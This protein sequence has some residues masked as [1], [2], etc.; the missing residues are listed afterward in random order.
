MGFRKTVVRVMN[1][2]YL[3]GSAVAIYG[4]CTKPI[5]SVDLGVELSSKQVGKVVAKAF[6]VEDKSESRAYTVRLIS[7]AEESET[8]KDWLTEAKIAKA[9]PN[10]LSIHKP[11]EIP[12]AKA[13]EFKNNKIVEE[14]VAN[15]LDAFINEAV[16][17]ITPGVL[18]LFKEA[19]EDK[20]KDVLHEQ[21]DQTIADFFGDDNVGKVSDDEVQEIFDNIYALVENNSAS[22]DQIT[23]AIL[24]DD[25]TQAGL[26]K[27]LADR[28]A[29]NGGMQVAANVT[30]EEYDAEAAKPEDERLLFT[31]NSATDPATF[32]PVQPGE[33]NAETTYFEPYDSSKIDGEHISD[34]LIESLD[35]LDGMIDR[36]GEYTECNPKP[37]ESQYNAHMGEGDVNTK[38]YVMESE[39]HY[40]PAEGAYDPSESTKYY[41]EIVMI[42]DVDTAL[43]TLLDQLLNGGKSDKATHRVLRAEPEKSEANIKK[44]LNDYIR[45]YI[46]IDAIKKFSDQVGNKAAYALL[47][48]VVFFIF[49]WAWFALLTLIRALRPR[50][51]WTSAWMV[52][53]FAFPQLI[54]GI[55]LRYGTTGILA[56][57]GGKIPLLKTLT[58]I[59]SPVISFNCLWAS[60]VYLAMIPFGIVYAII[61][62]PLKSQLKFEK[63]IYLHEKHRAQYEARKRR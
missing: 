39:G 53:V 33:Y 54:L 47:G 11:I 55:V 32:V 40:V 24:G 36:T 50:K 58:D 29:A 34:A 25:E 9:F 57:L 21:I 22:A 46:P 44:T 31:K 48:L 42:N 18:N 19:A 28:A 52:F 13:F 16:D 27:I 14:T 37:T 41:K 15:N 62:H 61:A 56:A 59:F 49:P 8:F 5:A 26:Q 38:Y 1:L 45:K 6:G 60:F 3:A 7:R 17:K 51:V 12:F 10:G 30:Q 43:A 20:A 4:I 23:G 2:V 63:Q 35:S